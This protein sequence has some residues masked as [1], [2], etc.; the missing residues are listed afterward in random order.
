MDLKATLQTR[1]GFSAFREGQE[2]AIR[3]ALEASACC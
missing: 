3:A 2:A 1:F